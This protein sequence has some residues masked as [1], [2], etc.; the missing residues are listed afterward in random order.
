MQGKQPRP[1]M[2]LYG[3]LGFVGSG[4]VGVYGGTGK[5]GRC[6]C[7]GFGAGG[8]LIFIANNNGYLR[9]VFNYLKG[10]K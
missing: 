2:V 8:V 1:A 7:N 9:V 5:V 4:A 6:K 10:C 3:V